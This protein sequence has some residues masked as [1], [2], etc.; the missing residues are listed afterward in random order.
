MRKKKQDIDYR[1][2]I[3]ATAKRSERLDSINRLG[4]RIYSKTVSLTQKTHDT[5]G[6]WVSDSGLKKYLRHKDYPCHSHSV[7]AIIDDYCGARHAFFEIRKAD[8]KARPPFKRRWYHTFTWRASGITYK[9]GK[10]RL[11]M[12][13]GREPLCIKIDKKFHKKVP[14]EV[15]LVY[16]R[17]THIYEFHATYQTQPAKYKADRGSVVAVDL[18]EIHPIVSFEGLTS[19]I[20]NGR[21]LR[22]I[23][24]Y[25]EKF[26]ATINHLL[27][28]CKRGSRR[29]KKLKHAKN[30]TLNNLR[31]LIRDVRH[32]I[33]SRFVSACKAKKAETIVIGDIKHIRQ[34]ID[35][36]PKA[37]Q[38]LHQWSFGEFTRM[39]TYKAKA[40]GIKVDS[41]D[42]RYTSQTC[43]SCGHRKK[44]SKRTYKC[45]KCQWTGH[46]DVVGASNILTKYQ[47]WLFN[48]VVGA[49]VSPVGIRYHPDLCRLDKWSP[50]SGLISSK[51]PI[52]KQRSTRL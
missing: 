49:V 28:R 4:G 25:R 40:V 6:F 23:V 20:Y 1:S 48:P 14:A 37:N 43:P 44:S 13:R 19:E 26:K 46:R 47:G 50:F 51:S 2:Y 31:N 38:K 42:E 9:R 22:S 12:G 24:Q 18:G 5:K 29:W 8:P 17:D 21:Y 35:Y 41:Q 7:Q 11:S 45:S 34:S 10:L 15:S 32:K 33:T 3:V 27:S 16:N 30:R 36:G 39:I 52:R